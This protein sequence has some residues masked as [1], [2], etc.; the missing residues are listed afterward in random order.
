MF[1]NDGYYLAGF[2]QYNYGT[3]LN[4]G[5]IDA[6]YGGGIYNYAGAMFT[7]EGKYSTNWL[8][9]FNPG[10]FVN[11]G[12]FQNKPGAI[13]DNYGIFFQ[14][15][16]ATFEDNGTF[17]YN[18][19]GAFDNSGSITNL[20]GKVIKNYGVYINR[21]GA[22][23]KNQGTLE[24]YGSGAQ[25]NPIQGAGGLYGDLL[26]GFDNRGV[27]NNT[28]ASAKLDNSGTFKTYASGRL[29]NFGT[30]NVIKGGFNCCGWT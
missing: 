28:I 23:F 29:D 9:G 18:D 24:N 2:P 21:P 11:W 3:F 20:A 6:Q 25:Y 1:I 16:G 14:E 10:R 13:F 7:N 22:S 26:A 19:I 8:E 17:N 5:T 27:F 30:I 15:S 4:R 12:T